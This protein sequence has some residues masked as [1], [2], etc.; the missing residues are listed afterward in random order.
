MIYVGSIGVV[1][2]WRLIGSYVARALAISTIFY[3]ARADVP[4]LLMRVFCM[5]ET[6]RG[7]LS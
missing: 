3:V 4:S 5:N 2:A 1:A 7:V 6:I